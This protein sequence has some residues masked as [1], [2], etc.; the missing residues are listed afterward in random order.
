MM[1][2]I[3]IFWLMLDK[4]RLRYSKDSSCFMS[5]IKTAVCDNTAKTVVSKLVE[6]KGHILQMAMFS[7]LSLPKLAP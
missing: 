1:G 7:K 3:C 6:F 5:F 2:R 4:F